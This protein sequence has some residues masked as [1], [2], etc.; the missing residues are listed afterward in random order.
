M[1][2]LKEAHDDAP[3]ATPRPRG[4]RDRGPR[5]PGHRH[6]VRRGPQRRRPAL[7]HD[8]IDARSTAVARARRA[9]RHGARLALLSHYLDACQA[10]A[11]AHAQGVIHRDLKPANIMLGAFGETQVVDWGLAPD[12]DTPGAADPDTDPATTRAGAIARHARVHEPRA[13]AR[14]A[15]RSP[16][17]RLGPRRRAARA[18]DRV[19]PP[20][21]PAER[22]ARAAAAREAPDAPRARRRSSTAPW[23]TT[24]RP[25][26][27]RRG[28]GRRRRRLPRGPPVQA[29]HYTPWSSPSASSGWR[30][31]C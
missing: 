20:P 8:A 24:P 26:P 31:R 3:R 11:Y 18:A 7:L 16:L 17:R 29:H 19:A 5:A 6:R 23:P 15:G 30:G 27:R 4:A 13:G 28:P 10:L 9:H 1:V 2:A 25:L 21:R 12:G 14:R 22:R